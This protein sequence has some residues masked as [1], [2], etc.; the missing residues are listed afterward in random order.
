MSNLI[1]TS[2]AARRLEVTPR[3]ISRMVR[4]EKLTPAAKTPGIRG[5]FMFDSEQV[6]DLVKA[7]AS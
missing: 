7:R 5:A 3:Q 2:E 1:P 6:D 4:E